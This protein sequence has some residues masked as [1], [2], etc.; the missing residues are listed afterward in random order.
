M[1]DLLRA[2]PWWG[3][4]LFFSLIGLA[5]KARKPQVMSV[6]KIFLM[7]LIFTLWSLYSVFASHTIFFST[8]IW[9]PFLVAGA[10]FGWILYRPVTVRADHKKRLIEI[11]GTWATLALVLII[12]IIEYTLGYLYA[13]HPKADKSHLIFGLRMVTSGAITGIF[14]GKALLLMQK[15]HKAPQTDL[16]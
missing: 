3:Y 2:I 8:F 10:V 7:P 6:S 13:K 4:I 16:T 9:L 1:L 11:P 12:F 14:A 15:F 5:L